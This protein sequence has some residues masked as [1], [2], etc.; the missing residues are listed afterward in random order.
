MTPSEENTPASPAWHRLFAPL[1]EGV[2]PQRKP[3]APPEVLAMPEGAA[4]AGWEQLSVDLS[5]GAAGLRVVLVVLDETG[6]PISASDMV[7]Y[8]AE[9]TE[10]AETATEFRHESV[11][12]RLEADGSFRGTRWYTVNIESADEHVYMK[13]STPSQPS[14]ADVAALNV[15]VAEML[16]R[17]PGKVSDDH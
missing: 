14:E 7:M 12:G 10:G 6:R 16:R 1:P 5:A 8:C 9:V 3:V 2:V 13:E 15:L 4:I 11:G 17:A